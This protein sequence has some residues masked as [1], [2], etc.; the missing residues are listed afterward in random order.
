MSQDQPQSSRS[1]L[2]GV[3]AIAGYI[4]RS[5]RQTQYLI[6]RK[7][8]TVKKLGP[9]TIIADPAEIDADL[10]DPTEVDA[11]PKSESA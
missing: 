9:K 10:A 7:R 1:Y 2:W 11:S 6:E 4:N 3:R 8:L 5:E